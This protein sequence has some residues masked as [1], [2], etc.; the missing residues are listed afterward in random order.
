MANSG[1]HEYRRQGNVDEALEIATLAKYRKISATAALA[2]AK[3]EIASRGLLVTVTQNYFNVLS[4]QF[5]FDDA[6]RATD[7]ASRF[8]HPPQQLD[9]GGESAHPDTIK[10]E[11]QA[12]Y[13]QRHSQ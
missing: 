6:R 7:E 8:L 11:R 13:R 2:R 12:P 10:A 5:K 3:A 1:G 4:A 9:Q